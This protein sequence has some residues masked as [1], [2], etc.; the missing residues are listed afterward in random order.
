MKPK[1]KGRKKRG[2]E[3]PGV[4]IKVV[5]IL[6]FLTFNKFLASTT[7]EHCRTGTAPDVMQFTGRAALGWVGLVSVRATC[8]GKH[9]SCTRRR[10]PHT[11]DVQF[12]ARKFGCV[13]RK[14]GKRTHPSPDTTTEGIG[15]FTGHLTGTLPVDFAFG[16]SVPLDFPFQIFTG[17]S[18]LGPRFTGTASHTCP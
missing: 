6:W 16:T 3:K 4:P 7:S 2:S 9:T 11:F 15:L 5:K 10:G 13:V 14:F 12:A 17:E 8:T 18:L 1:K